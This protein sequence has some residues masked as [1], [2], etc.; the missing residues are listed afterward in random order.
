MNA[1]YRPLVRTTVALSWLLVGSAAAIAPSPAIATAA[2]EL[3]VDTATRD[4]HPTRI[5]IAPGRGVTLDFSATGQQLVKVWLDDP[6]QIAYDFDGCAIARS[7]NCPY[8]GQAIHLRR[9]EPIDFPGLPATGRTLLT[10]IA[11]DPQTGERSRYHFEVVPS[12]HASVVGIAIVPAAAASPVASADIG[13]IASG[14]QIVR[15]RQQLEANSALAERLDRA[16]ALMRRGTPLRTAARQVGVSL[17]LLERLETLGR[18][19]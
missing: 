6:S 10:A 5:A 1:I 8:L 18:S 13:A 17:A 2:R 14:L 15:D 12:D 16:I 3:S 4:R 9:I 11:V 19:R 7:G